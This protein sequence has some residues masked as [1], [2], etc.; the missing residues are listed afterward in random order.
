MNGLIEAINARIAEIENAK[1]IPCPYCGEDFIDEDMEHVTFHGGEKIASC[2]ECHREF[3]VREDVSRT[4]A[5]L[6]YENGRAIPPQR[7]F[8]H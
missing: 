2:Q 3:V 7:D 5:T 1:R 6:Q 4:Y 8:E